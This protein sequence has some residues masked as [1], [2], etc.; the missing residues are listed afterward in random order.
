MTRKVDP[1]T[2]DVDL[3]LEVR[4]DGKVK[5][6]CC[7]VGEERAVVLGSIPRA[8]V[9]VSSLGVA[10]VHLH[11]EREQGHI[12]VVPGYDVDLRVN[13]VLARGPTRIASHAVLE[14]AG[15]RVDA[16]V[17]LTAPTE[18]DTH[19]FDIPERE[20]GI[21]YL[22][23]L[24]SDTQTTRL[25][26]E[27]FPRIE[28]VQGAIQTREALRASPYDGSGTERMARA[29]A[30]AQVTEVMERVQIVPTA[31]QAI[32]QQTMRMERVAPE[33][34]YPPAQPTPVI[35]L[36]AVR[37]PPH[38]AEQP[39]PMRPAPEQHSS[40]SGLGW[41][42]TTAFDLEG[43]RA[44][45]VAAA[46]TPDTGKKPPSA[47]PAVGCGP[48]AQ[49]EAPVARR[50]SKVPPARPHGFLSVLGTQAKVHPWRVGFAGLG[51]S[52]VLV[53]VLLGIHHAIVGTPPHQSPK[54]A[55]RS[56]VAVSSPPAAAIAPSTAALAVAEEPKPAATGTL[57]PAPSARSTAP[58]A[59]GHRLVSSMAAT[60]AS[61]LISGR[62]VDATATY[63]Q[64]SA[65]D[66]S[67]PALETA[68]RLLARRTSS[69]CSGPRPST[70]CPEIVQ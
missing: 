13:A 63:A 56:S 18:T 32:Q 24:P 16:F 5:N 33:T 14:F 38:A 34:F 21:M 10:P 48:P 53:F 36:Q 40:P 52:A 64:A 23:S 25:A 59:R 49:S 68:H 44:D 31:P 66:Q 39:T 61:Q 57:A 43:L 29:S 55:A 22:S 26:M 19:S 20:S 28:N 58:L 9:R 42:Q 45:A 12:I 2:K 60:A 50:I 1:E 69:A 4:H 54:A 47:A 62:Y 15:V 65:G 3:W 67:N 51:A 30:L 27:P 70:S 41:Q 17:H 11:F 8:D 46:S 6:F 37:T 7:R 35:P